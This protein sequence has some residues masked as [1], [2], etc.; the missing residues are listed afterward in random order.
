[1]LKFMTNKFFSIFFSVLVITIVVMACTKKKS[2]E[3]IISPGY[4]TTGNPNPGLQTVTG[5]TTYTNPATENSSIYVGGT[6]WSNPTCG[7]TNSMTL[8]ATSGDIDVTLSFAKVITTG[9]YNISPTLSQNVCSI[10]VVNPPGQPAGTSWIGT[11]GYVSVTTTS[12]S[13]NAI[14]YNVVCTQASFSFPSVSV[15]GAIGCSQ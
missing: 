15:T 4:G 14:L 13:I 3:G 2:T 1:M 11:G 10:K 9:T 5:T 8:K 6:G 12:S 7:S